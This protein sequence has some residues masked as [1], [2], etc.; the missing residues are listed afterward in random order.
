MRLAASTCREQE[1]IQRQIAATATLENRRKIA[2][3]AANA[4][5]KEAIE[6]E[7]R[8]ARER[9]RHA[10]LDVEAAREMLSRDTGQQI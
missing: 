7:K 6:A 1:A 3:D 8:D 2:T 5:S 4:W 9:K 10:E